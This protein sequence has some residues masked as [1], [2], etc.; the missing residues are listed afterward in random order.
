MRAANTGISAVVDPRGRVAARTDLFE[1]TVLVEDV[2]LLTGQTFYSRYGDVFAWTC[3]A[4]AALF[5]AAT[6]LRPVRSHQDL[7]HTEGG[8]AA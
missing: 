6:L 2:A 7:D 3:L 4:A 1:R 8:A 5:T